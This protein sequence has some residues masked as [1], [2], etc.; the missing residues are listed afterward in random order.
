MALLGDVG[1]LE[2]RF[3]P[4]GDNVSVCAIKVHDLRQMYHGLRKSFCM[5]PMVLLG[6]KAQVETRFGPFGD[7]VCVGTR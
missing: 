6:D 4:Y 3:G 2:S 5:H 1:Q 7:N